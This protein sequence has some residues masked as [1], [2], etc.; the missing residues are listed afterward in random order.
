VKLA[1][2]FLPNEVA[3]RYGP[4][5]AKL[6]RDEMRR[7]GRPV[8]GELC[9]FLEDIEACGRRCSE[10]SEHDAEQRP[11]ADGTVASLD[12][13]ADATLERMTT[14]EAAVV[15]GISRRRVVALANAR[16]LRGMKRS[17]E[18]QLD[19]FSVLERMENRSD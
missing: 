13:S 11:P 16:R 17:G 19:R 10:Y 1:G 5:I 6:V 4:G 12:A 8:L 15:L 3:A 2:V 7:S 18:W 9:E 14:A